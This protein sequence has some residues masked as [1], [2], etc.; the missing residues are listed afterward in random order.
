M[1]KLTRTAYSTS[2]ESENIVA[3]WF[4]T[5]F[6]QDVDVVQN[7]RDLLAEEPLFFLWV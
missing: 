6:Y 7:E 4:L 1:R 5:L 2:E 3:S